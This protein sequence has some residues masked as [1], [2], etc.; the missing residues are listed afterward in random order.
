MWGAGSN[1]FHHEHIFADRRDA[2][3]MI[4]VA[5][6]RDHPNRGTNNYVRRAY[7][8]TYQYQYPR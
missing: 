2:H 7:R 3:Q 6:I 8:H 5:R 1:S 4:E